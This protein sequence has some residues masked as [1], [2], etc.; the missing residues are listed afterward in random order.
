MTARAALLPLA[1]VA[2]LA[3]GLLP[4][5]GQVG[6]E[7]MPDG[8]RGLLAQ[9][10][11]GEQASLAELATQTHGE[12]EWRGY[13]GG[14]GA[15]LTETEIE[16]LAGYLSVN[17][18]IDDTALEAAKTGG[19][20]MSAFPADGKELAVANCQFCHSI[21][22]GYLMQ[23]RD[24][25]G[26]RNTFASPFHREIQMTE[27]QRETFALYSFTNTPLEYEDVPPELRF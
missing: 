12:A 21:F 16:T 17:L 6:F 25:Q 9:L 23:D 20:L 8:G 3:V 19:D 22:S 27:R 26:W 15:D 5:S 10:F 1:L 14:L 13:L 7:F 11:G 4:A 18:P 2:T 24:A